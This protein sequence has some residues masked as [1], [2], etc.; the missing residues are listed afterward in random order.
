VIPRVHRSPVTALSLVLLVALV[1][2]C[3]RAGDGAET[4]ESS[5]SDAS[6]ATDATDATDASVETGETAREPDELSSDV[7]A[8]AAAAAAARADDASTV[9]RANARVDPDALERW[10]AAR[11]A[12]TGLVPAA[13]QRA[14]DPA[15]GRLALVE[16]GY[17]ACG[18]PARVVRELIAGQPIVTLPDREAG[19]RDLPFSMNLSSDARGVEIA[20][21]NC[22]ACHGTP[23]FG[24]L[25]I[26][27][28]NEF[29]DFTENP[30]V[31]VERAGALVRGAGE[32]AAWERYADR[33]QAI[34]PYMTMATV[35]TNPAN[36][37][38]FALIAHRDAATNAWSDEP[39]LPLPTTSPPPVSVP[40]WWRMSKKHAMF[41]LGEARGDHG[42]IMMAAAM[43]CSDTVAELEAI[44]AYAPDIRAYIAGL[45]PP[46]WPFPLDAALV[47]RGRGVFET[48]C[49]ACH[50]HYAVGTDG[51]RARGSDTYP[52]RLVPIELL[53][54][55]PALVDQ[56]HT[57][58]VPYIDWFNR[59]FYG[60][61]STA[62]PGPG[63]V[64]PPLD[65]VWA[66]GPFLHNGSVPSVRAL[67]D[68][69]IRPA[70]WHHVARDASDP[71]SY[72]RDDLGWRFVADEA[73]AAD[74]P[75]ER[76]YDTARAG[77]AATG[78]RFGDHLSGDERSAV[79][80]YL[81]TL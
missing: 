16:E 34:A 40:P 57:E 77:H 43:L 48:H 39:L 70:R 44:D 51:R 38:T 37:L 17:V 30:S 55:D 14:G 75:P 67:L 68:S 53:G 3:G 15:R 21:S 52:N 73:I 4:I 71:A 18:L 42:R 13:S 49:A 35:G 27:L 54:T 24:E 5:A 11:F 81:K 59:S 66:T 32:T 19:A 56:A 31:A 6:D 10:P 22:L 36:N 33:V 20:S 8:N 60:E 2:G 62:A 28:G 69:T 63:H 78:H 64:A 46:A 29:L 25:V 80:E 79:I 72:D 1:G 61:L 45:E 47:A 41:N 26:G 7:P 74:M 23:L 76:I 58:G 50:G 9:G 12:D 65:G